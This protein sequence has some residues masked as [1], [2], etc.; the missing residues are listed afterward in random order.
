MT[1]QILAIP[2]GLRGELE[3]HEIHV[4]DLVLYINSSCNLRCAHCYVGNALLNSSRRYRGDDIAKFVGSFESLDR[5][6]I[7]GGEPFLHPEINQIVESSISISIADRRITSNLTSLFHFDA[8]RFR[9]SKLTICGSIDG[10]H[11]AQHD[12]IRGTGTFD[13]TIRTIDTLTSLKYD[14]EITHTVTANNISEIWQTI[15]LCKKLGVRKLNLHRISEHG[16][17]KDNCHLLVS[18][19]EWVQLRLDLLQKNLPESERPKAM[20]RV[21][22]PTLFAT[23]VS[24][25]NLT[26]LGHYWPLAKGSYYS[27]AKGHR[28][29]LYPDEKLYMSS[30]LF[31]SD[32]FIGH[33]Q[34][35]IFVFNSSAANELL[36]PDFAHRPAR[37]P[38][39]HALVPLSYSFKETMYFS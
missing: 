32:S 11:A 29:V 23:R 3:A 15:D 38:A 2:E 24:Y 26:A 12:A 1:G 13:Q 6:T 8:Q 37:E 18:P 19:N 9:G 27:S 31:G 35:G 16:N 39:N 17:A 20:L 14:L 36:T 22:V 25:E 7:L 28:I 33:L 30:E 4:H 10:S 34:N 21:R 5:I